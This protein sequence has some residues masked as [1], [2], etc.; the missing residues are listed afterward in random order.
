MRFPMKPSGWIVVLTS[1]ALSG[2]MA[3][4]SDE[5]VGEAEQAISIGQG[6]VTCNSGWPGRRGCT[7]Y[8]G[9]GREIMPG[10]ITIHVVGHNGAVEKSAELIDNNRRIK[11]TADIHEGNAFGPGDNTTR[12]A[13]AWIYL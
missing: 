13:L 1:L 12:F 3:Q 6:S 8:F 2:C 10:T 5:V 7:A 11:F 9:D 4:E